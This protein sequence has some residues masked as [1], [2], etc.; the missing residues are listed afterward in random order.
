MASSR[1][2]VRTWAPIRASTPATASAWAADGRL[3]S[4]AAH[5]QN[6]CAAGQARSSM[7]FPSV[8]HFTLEHFTLEPGQVIHFLFV[9]H[10]FEG[11]GTGAT[12][13]GSC[14]LTIWTTSGGRGL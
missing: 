12:A 4:I 14:P 7:G 8:R 3:P 1:G 5:S 6:P 9:L 10:G 13:A 11:A 2:S